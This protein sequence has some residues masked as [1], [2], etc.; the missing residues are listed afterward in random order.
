MVPCVYLRLRLHCCQNCSCLTF[1]VCNNNSSYR[2][3]FHRGDNE[4]VLFVS[5]LLNQVCSR[6]YRQ[7]EK[8]GRAISGMIIFYCFF[9]YTVLY[10]TGTDVKCD[11]LTARST[12]FCFTGVPLFVP[13]CCL[14][15]M[16]LI[17][18]LPH[19]VGIQRDFHQLYFQKNRKLLIR[20]RSYYE[21]STNESKKFLFV[22]YGTSINCWSSSNHDR[23]AFTIQ[24]QY[25][26]PSRN[27]L[28]LKQYYFVLFSD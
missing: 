11:M 21:K 16:F 28:A 14:F 4:S 20:G 27:S 9:N 3:D 1:L 2:K 6:F 26:A 17:C 15:S 25:P 12:H 19:K 24:T 5:F 18:S 7:N 8:G 10:I 22:F 13:N 23:R